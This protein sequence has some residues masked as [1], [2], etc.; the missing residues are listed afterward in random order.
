MLHAKPLQPIA[1]ALLALLTTSAEANLKAYRSTVISVPISLTRDDMRARLGAGIA[2][3]YAPGSF[4][5]V[6]TPNSGTPIVVEK[7]TLPQL[8][9]SYLV[10][11]IRGL[12][13]RI[14][15]DR[16]R[17][18]G[19]V[20]LP[21]YGAPLG[22][23]TWRFSPYYLD[24]DWSFSIR[25][26]YH[27]ERTAGAL[28]PGTYTVKL[29]E[30]I[31]TNAL[32]SA[33][34]GKVEFQVVIK[35]PAMSCA[36]LKTNERVKLP[37]ISTIDFSNASIGGTVGAAKEFGLHLDCPD[38]T[39]SFTVVLDDSTGGSSD[40]FLLAPQSTTS[41]VALKI[42]TS[43]DQKPVRPSQPM[44]FVPPSAAGLFT[45][46]FNVR[47]VKTESVVIPGDVKANAT[48]TITYD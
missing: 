25:T 23:D 4:E 30:L 40:Y 14:W 24:G 3:V 27:V 11:P 12:G 26:K 35:V 48:F 8:S 42:E 22:L 33:E 47:Y 5:F 2:N 44:P 41:G 34:H 6:S 7:Y 9:G 45:P 20:S 21:F 39:P 31:A 43:G 10:E 46:R 17:F 36:L 16:T 19:S 13:V 1:I 29:G 37:S 18:Y 32:D 38:E 28:I 15:L